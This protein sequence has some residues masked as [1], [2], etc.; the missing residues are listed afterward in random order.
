MSAGLPVVTSN[1]SALAEV[2]GDAALLV[3]P[4]DAYEI[5]IAIE[6]ALEEGPT[7]RRL[8][9]AGLQREQEFGWFKAARETLRVYRRLLE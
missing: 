1:R 5:R 2:A 9:H 3:N 6:E 7:R 4:E 8:I